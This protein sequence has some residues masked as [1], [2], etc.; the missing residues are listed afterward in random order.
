MGLALRK[1]GFDV[2]REGFLERFVAFK[3]VFS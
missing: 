2:F 3:R 1:G